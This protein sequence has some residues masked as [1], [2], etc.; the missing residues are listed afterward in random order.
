MRGI[1]RKG[2]EWAY[3][4]QGKF[5][6]VASLCIVLFTLTGSFII[7]SREEKLYERDMVNQCKVIAEISKVTL[8]NVMV[9]NEL[10]MMDRQDLTDYLD[11]FI[12]NLMERDNRIRFAVA[13]DTQG[14]ILADSSI[15]EYRRT[16]INESAVRSLVVLDHTEIVEGT[17]YGDPV[18]RITVPLNIDTK[19]WGVIQIGLSLTEMQQAIASLKREVAL[20]VVSFSALS[21]IIV[22]IGAKVLAKPVVRLSSLMDRIETHGDL[23]QFEKISLKER[24]DELGRL[25]KSFL[26]MIQRLREADKEHKKTIE[27]LAQTEKMVSIGRLASGV[28]HEVNNPLGGITICFKNLMTTEMDEA[29]REEHIEVINDSLQ[30][31]KRIVEQLLNFSKITVAEMTETDVNHLM[32]KMLL[33]LNYITYKKDIVVV[34]DLKEDMPLIMMDENKMGQV[35]MNIMLNAVQSMD[36]GGTLG[37]RTERRDGFCAIRIRDTGAGIPPEV[38]PSIFDPFFTTKSV[39]EGTGLGLSISKSIVEQH[40]GIIE[41]ESQVGAGTE[42][43]IKLPLTISA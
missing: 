42:F 15:S 41:V 29:T 38:L 1:V 11:Y 2:R 7:I 26:W 12:M 25:Q 30:K 20:L 18:Y 32:D 35:L 22:S 33:L 36:D 27:V 4:L 40:G 16:H 31:I 43:R 9:F 8:T 39:G 14:N 24:R 6:L 13:L 10:G 17:F 19:R 28:A 21:L 23:E 3:S 37:I 34:K 5:I